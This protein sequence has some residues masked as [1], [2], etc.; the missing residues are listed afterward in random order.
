[1]TVRWTDLTPAKLAQDFEAL[2][3]DVAVQ[4]LAILLSEKEAFLS[5]LPDG[6]A[7][8]DP[9][10]RG[11]R[12][13]EVFA[14]VTAHTDHE[15][16]L[17]ARDLLGLSASDRGF[18]ERLRRTKGKGTGSPRNKTT[19]LE[20]AGE[21][22]G[23]SART[24]RNHLGAICHALL[25]AVEASQHD[26]YAAAM[27]EEPGVRDVLRL[28]DQYAHELDQAFGAPEGRSARYS[29][30]LYV[31]R[32]VEEELIAR[33]ADSEDGPYR[34]AVVG[35]AGYGK[36]SLLWGL[37]RDLADRTDHGSLIVNAAWL[38]AE[39][40]GEP[41]LRPEPLVRTV[42]VL[43]R[44][45]RSPVVLLDTV[46]LLMHDANEAVRVNV[47][48]DRLIESGARVVVTCRRQES[49]SLD[50][51]FVKVPITTYDETELPLAIERHVAAFCPDAPPKPV[52]EKV[53]I[54]I[55]AA[56]RGL[57][58]QEVCRH[59]LLLR[60][61][62]EAYD[63]VFPNTEVDTLGVLSAYFSGK[64]EDD[65]SGKWDLHRSRDDVSF[66]CHTLAIALFSAG[67]V[68]LRRAGLLARALRV[69]NAW[70]PTT[71]ADL[72]AALDLLNRRGV[73]LEDERGEI[74]F[75][76]QLL[77]EYVVGRALLARGDAG[78]LRRLVDIV[79]RR[80]L[81]LYVGAVLEQAMIYAWQENPLLRT[82][83]SA[84]LT[85]LSVS[86]SVNLQSI[87]LVVA[88]HHPDSDAD[89]S[90]LLERASSKTVARY[91]ELT[92]R[93]GSVR[94]GATLALLR[95]VWRRGARPGGEKE[96]VEAVLNALERFA[97]QHG[98]AVKDFLI[99]PDPDA[100]RGT[101]LSCVEHVAAVGGDLLLSQRALPRTLGLLAEVDAEWSAEQLLTLFKAGCRRANRRALAVA[102]LEI[103][104]DRWDR[105]G[106]F[107]DRFVAA[108]VDAQELNGGQEVESVRLAA[109]RLRA[110]QWRDRY[111]LGGPDAHAEQW[112]D[113]VVDVRHELAAHPQ[114]R[115]STQIRLMGIALAL[116]EIPHD[117]ALIG[118]TLDEIF[119]VTGYGLPMLELP[120]SFLVPLIRSD[121]PAGARARALVL[122]ALTGLPADPARTDDPATLRASV[123]RT[124]INGA[125][126][127]PDRLAALLADVPKL[128]ETE[129]WIHPWGMIA[130]VVPAAVGGH[131][132][133]LAALAAIES[134]PETV[135][136]HNRGSITFALTASL[137]LHPELL[138]SA[139]KICE[140]W[141]VCVPITEAIRR[142]ADGLTS[143]LL[144]HQTEVDAMLRRLFAC[145]GS[146]QRDAVNLRLA[147]DAH[148]VLPAVTFDDLRADWKKAEVLTAKQ[149][150]LRLMGQQAGRGRL[151]L[152]KVTG[153]LRELIDSDDEGTGKA[154]RHALVIALAQVGP[155]T[156][157]SLEDL[158]ELATGGQAERDTQ[159]WLRLPL[160]RLAE[161]GRLD[162]AFA[163]YVRVGVKISDRSWNH[164][165]RMANK[166]HR[167]LVTL[168]RNAS[169][170]Q[171]EGWIDALPTL[172][173]PLAQA[174]VRSLAEA[175]FDKV[176]APLQ[177][178]AVRDEL[179]AR[180]A[181]TIKTEL[182]ERTRL[183]GSVVMDELLA[184]PT[185]RPAG[186][187]P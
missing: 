103:V 95:R 186:E 105:F 147:L 46:D 12:L 56:S 87:A 63:G 38:H 60:L 157:E 21:R 144:H 107:A 178:A 10:A 77:F 68:A 137:G 9:L 175:A 69:A 83:V 76:H 164:Q 23:H 122:D 26:A 36:S 143:H 150:I 124:A 112:Q 3:T 5:A 27:L 41:I 90:E 131:P 149:N 66:E 97:V 7:G 101:G 113:L 71:E 37:H 35:E 132:I 88:A 39:P 155:L 94:I 179:S 49:N 138:P 17:Q 70:R 152:A 172:S 2:V 98:Q 25:A 154:A 118:A 166:M 129:M 48:L 106:V 182:D 173:E 33:L 180:V 19:R 6:Q 54:M 78:E 134:A 62:F 55:G 156:E 165:N 142:H 153:L 176:R 146:A 52:E 120:G 115:L 18:R 40:G 183:S 85:T 116:A 187:A 16:L 174:L 110:L 184:A 171:Q 31:I 22:T 80:T 50:Q 109:G 168:C 185:D 111:G 45:G 114:A 44:C 92:P 159:A 91:V 57:G 75:R 86:N 58:I 4:D 79:R 51:R 121:G 30:G 158:L 15:Q 61:L 108:T 133:A 161:S 148:E 96:C 81:D 160:Q 117:D 104:A 141:R 8:D 123:S 135:T 34:L 20:L 102:I 42:E 126:F 67:A 59:P 74:R 89:V 11:R 28:S 139:L 145:G 65:V 162:E 140:A 181:D 136:E 13:A 14:L 151:P 43:H 93:V 72:A 99:A 64:I 82:D 128:R 177:D 169:I 29:A 1:M 24:V 100:G 127:A 167:G 163:F 130:F 32:K 170:T 47:M 84:A 119:P 53:K 73:T 125:R